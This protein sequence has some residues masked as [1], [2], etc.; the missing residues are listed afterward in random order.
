MTTNA[1]AVGAGAGVQNSHQLKG[2]I[3]TNDDPLACA[4]CSVHADST[5]CGRFGYLMPCCGKEFCLSCDEHRRDEEV[6][7]FCPFGCPPGSDKIWV[8][9]LKRHAKRGRPWAQNMLGRIYIEGNVVRPSPSEAFRLFEMAAKNGSPQA[10]ELMGRFYLKGNGFIPA[11]LSKAWRH[12]DAALSLVPENDAC[13]NGLLKV[14][15][16][17]LEKKDEGSRAAAKSILL[18]V[19]GYRSSSDPK[20]FDRSVALYFLG[21]T[22]QRESNYGEA[23]NI[24]TECVTTCGSKKIEDVAYVQMMCSNAQ[25]LDAQS[26]F[27]LRQ[28][29]LSAIPTK[30]RR[31]AAKKYISQRSDLRKLRDICGACGTEFEG[32]D[33]KFCGGCRTFC[34]C[35]RK[36]QKMH[37]NSKEYG[38]REDCLGLKDLKMKLKEAKKKKK[39]DEYAN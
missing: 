32:K 21:L 6:L 13:L 14:S 38:H 25:G 31:Q 9:A 28:I 23:Y 36:C 15:A 20:V 34:Y 18:S 19:T 30:S 5:S 33:R 1:D 3:N 16:R 22:F 2:I 37:W 8:K 29:N 7:F 17:Y 35:S 39:S 26:R 24:F 12:F 27:W 10:M 11:D 4:L